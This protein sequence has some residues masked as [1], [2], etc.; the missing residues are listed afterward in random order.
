MTTTECGATPSLRVI[1]CVE[2]GAGLPIA[3]GRRSVR[4]IFCGAERPVP[5]LGGAVELTA[6]A[7]SA[8]REGLDALRAAHARRLEPTRTQQAVAGMAWVIVPASAMGVV[9]L[10]LLSE[11]IVSEGAFPFLTYATLGLGALGWSLSRK[12]LR[13]WAT[14][15]VERLTKR[16]HRDMSGVVLP[17]QCPSCGGNLQ[18]PDR[19]AA[20]S[21]PFC[22]VPLLASHGMVARWAEDAEERRLEWLERANDLLDRVRARETRA[23]R[24]API[25]MSVAAMGIALSSAGAVS[26]ALSNLKLTQVAIVCQGVCRVD[27]MTCLKG[28]K[29]TIYLAPGETKVIDLWVAPG[30]W[31]NERVTVLQGE[32]RVFVCPPTPNAPTDGGI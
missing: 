21:C 7:E 13:W 23:A 16:A 4:C 15:E 31:K 5:E 14:R 26:L 20:L 12:W 3:L 22:R 24:R 29:I 19:A 18:V 17:G 25:V 32:R 2:C 30:R 9:A 27:G 1:E 6:R 28:G 11:G 10:M 8:E